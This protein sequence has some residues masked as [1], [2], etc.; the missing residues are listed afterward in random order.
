M[1][2]TITI[3]SIC[4]YREMFSVDLILKTQAKSC[5]QFGEWRTLVCLRNMEV[6]L[7]VVYINS[8][9][10]QWIGNLPWV[11]FC[12][13]ESNGFIL[14][15]LPRFTQMASYCIVRLCQKKYKPPPY[16]LWLLAT[17]A[18][19][20]LHSALDEQYMFKVWNGYL[21]L[22]KNHMLKITK[23]P[24]KAWPGNTRQDKAVPRRESV[25]SYEK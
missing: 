22:L 15:F 1:H 24:E 16:M 23:H 6:S 12:N 21:Y 20:G 11:T 18:V 2:L 14:V 10:A 4:A 25:R 8:S 3:T 9:L 5:C 19:I 17:P 7:W 13:S